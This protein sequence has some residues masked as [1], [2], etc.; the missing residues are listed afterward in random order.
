MDVT[1]LVP[2]LTAW[3][4]AALWQ[5]TRRAPA[6]G[7]R[8]SRDGWGK[9]GWISKVVPANKAILKYGSGSQWIID[10]FPLEPL[11]GAV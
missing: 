2:H 9:P 8:V 7:M 11:H 4:S 10:Y 3:L 5:R 1:F 6:A